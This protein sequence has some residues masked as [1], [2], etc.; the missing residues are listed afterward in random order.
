MSE[1]PVLRKNHVYQVDI[2]ALSHEG[3]GLATLAGQRIFIEGALPGE[4]VKIKLINKK[5]KIW[6]ALTEEVI[7]SAPDRQKPPCA[8]ADIC[9][10]C[11]LQHMTLD[12]QHRMKQDTLK[13]QLSHF[14]QCKV[15]TL[16]P[17]LKGDTLGYRKKARLGVRFV[18][19]KEKVLV[20]FRE[21]SSNF[22][23]D[24]SQ[25]E[26]LDPRVGH[27]IV[28]IQELIAG[29]DAKKTIPQIEVAASADDV[30]LVFRHLEPL[31]E[32]DQQAI[33]AFCQEHNYQ[34]FYQPQGPATVHRVWPE[35]DGEP[36]LHYKLDDLELAFHPMD[37]TQVNASINEQM[38][39]RAIEWLQVTKED[40]VLDLFCGLGNFTLPLAQKARMVIGV[41][42]S[43][44][45]VERGYENLKNNNLDNGD[46]FA[47]DLFDEDS[48]KVVPWERFSDEPVKV[49]LDP[50]R[51]GAEAVCK[52][53]INKPV[54]R[55][56]YV[57]CNAATLARDTAI[58]LEGGFTCEKAGMMDMFPHTHHMESIA[59]FT[60]E[61]A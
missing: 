9:G 43:D 4:T 27:N 34:L 56:V 53:L 15:E 57:S 54:E 35:P 16:E 52:Q 38:I 42:G 40:Q 17:V 7:T 36:R 32:S 59:L 30:A 24:M 48:L 45:M 10:G 21:K 20:G 22:L 47:A 26:V 44:A 2:D 11:S 58:L 49:L 14:G 55:I 31:S 8:A 46:F 50:P 5:K 1:Q 28:A 13:Q 12:A 6:S 61:K 41:E 39:V 29:L 19:K 23:A 3:R 25:C 60:R 18:P 37:F 33:L 51:S